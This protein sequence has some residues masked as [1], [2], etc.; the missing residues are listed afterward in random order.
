MSS[1]SAAASP[2]LH[3]RRSFVCSLLIFFVRFPAHA[4]PC[5]S[6]TQ[7]ADDCISEKDES[8]ETMLLSIA[9][10]GLHK[11]LLPELLGESSSEPV[12]EFNSSEINL[13]GSSVADCEDK[14]EW[15]N[16]FK[17]HGACAPGYITGGQPI[18]TH[19][20]PVTCEACDLL[21]RDEMDVLL[22]RHNTYRRAH[23][24]SDLT[25]SDTLASQSQQWADMCNWQ[26][27]DND[28]GEN[29]WG[30]S[31]SLNGESVTD[32]WYSE[33]TAYNF[34]NPGKSTGTIGHFTQVVWKDS[35]KIGCGFKK[36]P[37]L[38]TFANANFV[39]CEY[40]PRGNIRG[41]FEA[42]VLPISASL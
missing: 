16:W 30:G 2:Q 33:I 25:W 34:N 19:W 18:Q 6:S 13:L 38:G 12:I 15:C 5:A 32:S 29:L 4:S 28:A 20:C 40:L 42:N 8:D 39:V 14:S 1:G 9:R 10:G 21:D 7:P 26:H 36:C 22:K 24:A 31:A 27:S 3:I 37:R 41:S 17:K 35:T 23:G 11:K